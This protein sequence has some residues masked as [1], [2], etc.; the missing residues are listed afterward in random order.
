MEIGQCNTLP[1]ESTV[2][3]FNTDLRPISLTSTLS[4][5]AEACVIEQEIK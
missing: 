5:I 4:K 2:E 3:D 1:K